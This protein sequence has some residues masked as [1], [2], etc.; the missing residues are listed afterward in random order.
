M[1]CFGNIFFLSLANTRNRILF[2]KSLMNKKNQRNNMKK[3]CVKHN[4]CEQF[5]MMSSVS[6][7]VS[8]ELLFDIRIGYITSPLL[9]YAYPLQDGRPGL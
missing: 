6:V 9:R 7:S 3:R 8:T 2:V 4:L 5:L 1:H